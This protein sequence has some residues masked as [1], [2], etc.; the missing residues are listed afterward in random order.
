MVVKSSRTRGLGQVA[1][2]GKMRNAYRVL[3]RKPE[4]KRLLG[5]PRNT[6]ELILKLI[7]FDYDVNTPTC[8][9][10]RFLFRT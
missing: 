10:G 4:G 7:K 3:T 6:C 1:C 2:V 9:I 8:I 5:R